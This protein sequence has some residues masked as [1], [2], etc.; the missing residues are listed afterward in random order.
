[1]MFLASTAARYI[2]YSHMVTALVRFSGFA[3][4]RCLARSCL[5]FASRMVLWYC[6]Y[7][8]LCDSAAAQVKL[9]V[10]LSLEHVIDLE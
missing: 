5:N 4:L 10:K 3:E 8:W 2:R 7:C 6:W 1:M 9:V